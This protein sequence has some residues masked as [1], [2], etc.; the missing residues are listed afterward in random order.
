MGQGQ[1]P[2]LPK[3]V[4]SAPKAAASGADSGDQDKKAKMQNFY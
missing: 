2:D 3:P 1:R 4:P